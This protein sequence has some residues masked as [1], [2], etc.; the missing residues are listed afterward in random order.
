M[1][2]IQDADSR[3]IYSIEM[4]GDEKVIHINGYFYDTG[5]KIEKPWRCVEI[6]WCIVPLAEF[7]EKYNEDDAGG[8]YVSELEE[9]CKQYIGDISEAEA[10]Q[11]LNTYANG[12]APTPLFLCD[13]TIDTPCGTYI[14]L[15]V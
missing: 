11:E 5:D 3:E 2:N 7:I 10:Q 8:D 12:N 13:V 14:D 6:C 9:P 4:D 1:I 15:Q